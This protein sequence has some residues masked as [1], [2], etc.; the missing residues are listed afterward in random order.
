MQR[1]HVLLWGGRTPGRFCKCGRCTHSSTSHKNYS[2][3]ASYRPEY[4]ELGFRG[5]RRGPDRAVIA[6]AL[7]A[8]GI[9]VTIETPENEEINS[10][11]PTD[12]SKVKLLSRLRH[13]Q[14]VL[15]IV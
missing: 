15:W 4:G 3:S 1:T 13:F 14:V 10:V 9:D 12:Q 11:Q 8:K 6:A 7:K 2:L 5:A